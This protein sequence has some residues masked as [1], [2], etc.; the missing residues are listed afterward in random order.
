VLP[1]LSPDADAVKD[2][3][4]VVTAFALLASTGALTNFSD[5][6]TTAIALDWNGPKFFNDMLEW[7]FSACTLQEQSAVVL[8]QMFLLSHQAHP[9]KTVSLAASG[10]I[11]TLLPY[12]PKLEDPYP[13]VSQ[14]VPFPLSID[15]N[16]FDSATL[17]IQFARPP[18]PDEQAEI[19]SQIVT[20]AVATAMGA[21]GIAPLMPNECSVQFEPTVVFLG[22]ELEFELARFRAHRASLY[23]LAN[24]CIA[25]H[26]SILPILELRIEK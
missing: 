10:Q 17:R 23:G 8:A 11:T 25:L 19:E 21:Y 13:S 5:Q 26:Q 4:S 7:E 1:A 18:T 22:D 12:D 15:P 24:V 14:Y 20:W 2:Y 9:L 6:T 16:I 3:D